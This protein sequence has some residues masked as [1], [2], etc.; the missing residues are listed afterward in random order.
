MSMDSELYK[1][2]KERRRN[3][4]NRFI[5]VGTMSAIVVTGLLYNNYTHSLDYFKKQLNENGAAITTDT[6]YGTVD[7][8]EEEL[9]FS[10]AKV[11]NLDKKMSEDAIKI[12]EDTSLP[13]GIITNPECTKEIDVY[14][15]IDYALDIVSKFHVEY[16]VFLN[17]DGMFNRYINNT[18][19]INRMVNIYVSKLQANGIYVSVIGHKNFLDMLA[20]EKRITDQVE[21]DDAVQYTTGLIVDKDYKNTNEEIYDVIIGPDYVCAK[22]N[23]KAV[24]KGKYNEE[25]LF[26]DSYDYVVES[27]DSISVIAD[28]NDISTRTLINYNNIGNTI[29][30]GQVITIPNKNQPAYYR[31]IDLSSSQGCVNWNKVSSNIDFAILR[32]GYTSNAVGLDSPIV[33]DSYFHYNI[34]EC[35]KRNIPVGVYYTS[36]NYDKFSMEKEAYALLRQLNDYEVSL[37]IYVNIPDNTPLNNDETRR[38]ITDC[39]DY[40]CSIIKENGYTPGIY[41]NE[42]LEPLIPELKDKYTIWSYGGLHYND[43]QKYYDM[44]YDYKVDSNTPIFQPTKSGEPS[45]VGVTESFWLGYDYADRKVI[46]EWLEDSNAKVKRFRNK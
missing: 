15:E 13:T 38:N 6:E 30:P 45:M 40:F 24:I 18:D 21:G 7:K 32:A 44:N 9:T 17:V 37:P 12:L 36:C 2:K 35:N 10:L 27:G 8:E 3:N 19:D 14:E 5:L 20:S 46:D 1:T 29:Y 31:G 34:S 16:P 4:R 26:V 43:R 25:K 11:G 23:F 33:I 39:V 41:V 22:T 42:S 28:E